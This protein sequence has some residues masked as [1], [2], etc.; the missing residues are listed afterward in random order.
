MKKVVLF[1]CISGL[2]SLANVAHAALISVNAYSM[3]NGNTGS[4]TYHDDDYSGSGNPLLN[5]SFLSGGTG[6]LTDG[7]IANDLWCNTESTGVCGT[8]GSDINGLYVGWLYTAPT[9]TFSFDPGT[10]ID[11]VVIYADDSEFNRATNA[12]QPGAFGFGGVAAP[13][14]AEIF[15]LGQ[16]F[17]LGNVANGGPNRYVIDFNA[18]MTSALTLRLTG[19]SPWIFVSEIQFEDTSLRV[20]ANA[21][22]TAGI[23]AFALAILVWRR[24]KS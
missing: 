20:D 10:R 15:E 6:K 4:Y 1:L 2:L 24:K 14:A 19:L 12:V 9:I 21:P 7:V 8:I 22:A 3:V 13:A 23:F 17:N 5:G 16:T 18:I 11:R